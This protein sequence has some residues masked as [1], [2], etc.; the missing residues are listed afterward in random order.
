MKSLLPF[1]RLMSTRFS[2]LFAAKSRFAG[3]C[4][5][6]FFRSLACT[7]RLS[8][9]DSGSVFFPAH[10]SQ[11]IAW[12]FGGSHWPLGARLCSRLPSQA[13]SPHRHRSLRIY[14]KSTLSWQRH[15]G[16]RGGN[17]TPLVGLLLKPHFLL[18]LVLFPRSSAGG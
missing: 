10:T 16:S 13:G 1:S 2:T 4:G 18:S 11:H 8:T 5:R 6:K 15:S 14:P 7:P 3:E 9:C 12:R 17:C